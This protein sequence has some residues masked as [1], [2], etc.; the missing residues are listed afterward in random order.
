VPPQHG[1]VLPASNSTAAPLL[2]NFCPAIHDL[3]T[4]LEQC[5]FF[6]HS[7]GPLTANKTRFCQLQLVTNTGSLRPPYV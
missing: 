4:L 3:Q 6:R 1:M 7:W 2:R 5:F